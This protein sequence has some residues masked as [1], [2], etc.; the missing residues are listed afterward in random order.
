[1]A[2]RAAGGAAAQT[3]SPGRGETPTNLARDPEIALRIKQ[4][5]VPL[6]KR[7]RDDRN[8]VLRERWLRYYRI[9]S[10]RHD[11]QG[12]RGRTNT[13]F[14]VG[15]R[16]IEQWVTRLKRDLFPDQDWFACNALREDFEARVPA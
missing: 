12:Y 13:Y 7:T 4:E 9:W 3:L 11:Q 14:P 10:V 5:L 2:R 8:G 16:W 6:M 1:M 15:R